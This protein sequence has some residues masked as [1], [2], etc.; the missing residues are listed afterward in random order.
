VEADDGG[1]RRTALGGA[2]EIE[3]EFAV[4]VAGEGE[5]EVGLEAGEEGGVEGGSPGGVSRHWLG[6][7]HPAT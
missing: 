2:M 5:R 1:E 7:D 4:A 3:L 6:G